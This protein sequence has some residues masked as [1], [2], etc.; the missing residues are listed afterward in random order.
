MKQQLRII[1]MGAASFISLAVIFVYAASADPFDQSLKSTNRFKCKR[2]G[3]NSAKIYLTLSKKSASIGTATERRIHAS[4][5]NDW[6]LVH[7]GWARYGTFSDSRDPYDLQVEKQL[8]DGHKTGQI[9]KSTM[10][11]FD[12]V[13]QCTRLN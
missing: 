6:G 7:I 5:N 10:S 9:S 3:R 12:I 2:K 13:Y 4:L 1:G 8:I 11:G